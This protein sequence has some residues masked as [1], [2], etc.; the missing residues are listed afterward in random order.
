MSELNSILAAAAAAA[1]PAARATAD[2]RAGWLRAIADGLD[3]DSDRLIDIAGRETNLPEGRLRGEMT[4]TAFQARLFADRV[5]AGALLDTR[6][7]AADADWPMGPRPDIRRTHVPIGPVLV[8]AASNFPFA[9][10]VAGGDTVSA[11]AVGCPVVVKTHDGHAELSGATAEV[12]RNSLTSA[13]APQG[14]FAVI[15]EREDGVAAIQDPRIKAAGFTGSLAGG[16]ALYDLACARPAP[17]PFYG[18][19][20]S[21][22]PVVVTAAGWRERGSEICKGFTTSFAMGAGQFCTQPGVVLIPDME[23][24][25]AQCALPEVHPML[26]GRIRHGFDEA[27]AELTGHPDVRV[28]ARGPGSDSA[29]RPI[30]LGTTAEA[31]LADPTIVTTEMFGPA[32]ILVSYG[33]LQQALD[34]VASVGGALTAT[35]QGTRDLD[36]D[37]PALLEV[38]AGIAGRV[39][40]NEWPTGVTVSDAQQH[41]GPWPATTAPISTSVGMA[42]AQRFARPVAFQNVPPAGLP[43][44]LQE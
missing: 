31:V 21:T 6:I 43:E 36:P 37:A 18:E 13:G 12:V 33:D 30:L 41:G 17:I 28:L 39:V 38:M 3:A 34:V 32:S 11:L 27:V 10:S 1:R 25:V 35:I 26:N 19:L 22:N 4:R 23:G 42:A 40:Y 29:P 9:F 5:A 24:F 7:D 15:N 16:R 44:E 20:G 2:M 8:Y 14:I